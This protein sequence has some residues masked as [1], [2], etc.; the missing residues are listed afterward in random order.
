MP[1]QNQSKKEIN[2]P[3]THQH[4]QEYLK[5]ASEVFATKAD[6]KKFPTKEEMLK[7]FATKEDLKDF[8]T[9]SEFIEIKNEIMNS[10]DKISKKL[11]KHLTEETIH[12]RS[13]Q[14]QENDAEKLKERIVRVEKHIGL[15]PVTS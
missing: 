4:F 2:K 12:T 13:H 3:I 15:K 14:R 7:F 1:K 10:N 6:L 9:K 5:I 11:D 8:A